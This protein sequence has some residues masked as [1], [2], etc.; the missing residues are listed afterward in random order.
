MK[1]MS[2]RVSIARKNEKYNLYLNVFPGFGARWHNLK[3]SE[4]VV[5]EGLNRDDHLPSVAEMIALQSQDDLR[6]SQNQYGP[7]VLP[8]QPTS[9]GSSDS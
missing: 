1:Q 6:V 9:P 3:S 5:K 7:Q 8:S 4:A 2:G